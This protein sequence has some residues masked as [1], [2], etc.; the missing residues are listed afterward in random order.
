[1][2]LLR[3][4]LLPGVL[5]VLV[6]T[7]WALAQGAAFIIGPADAR[8]LELVSD[9]KALLRLTPA[10]AV[11]GVNGATLGGSFGASTDVAFAAGNFT[12]NGD[13]VWTVSSDDILVQSLSVMGKLRF[14]QI[15]VTTSDI[16][17]GTTGST[18]SI[19]LPFTAKKRVSFIPVIVNNAIPTSEARCVVVAGTSTAVCALNSGAVFSTVT[20]TFGFRAQVFAE[21]S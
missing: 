11:E 7:A 21:V 8:V 2:P 10:G 15:D 17:A 5:L 20:A 18:L 12:T 19:A 3:N 6:T 1:M 16:G 9:G 4:A 14:Y 13:K